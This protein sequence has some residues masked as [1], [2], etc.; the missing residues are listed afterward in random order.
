MQRILALAGKKGSGKDTLAELLKPEFHRVS[1][2][3]P[4]YEEVQK[5]FDLEDQSLLRNRGTKEA[6]TYRMSL[7]CCNDP[8]FIKVCKGVGLD[9]EAPQSPRT[10]LQLW[11]TEYRQVVNGQRYWVDKLLD[12]LRE[13]K[14]LS[15]CIPDMRFPHEYTSLLEYSLE[16]PDA[17]LDCVKILREVEDDANS[18]HASETAL[19]GFDIYSVTVINEE[20][21]PQA[22]V[23]SLKAKSLV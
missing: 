21:N 13:N 9:Y 12:I 19:N 2:A 1:F 6:P 11:G 15:Y 14:D 18:G 7:I 5:A 23:N 22:M 3:D 4:L 16:E 10:I 8:V 20:N 17:K